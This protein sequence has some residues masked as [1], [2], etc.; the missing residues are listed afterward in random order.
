MLSDFEKNSNRPVLVGVASGLHVVC[1]SKDCRRMPGTS[2]LN[3][4]CLSRSASMKNDTFISNP[5]VARVAFKVVLCHNARAF[6]PG[7]TDMLIRFKCFVKG[8]VVEFSLEY[9]EISPPFFK[10]VKVFPLF[11]LL[12]N[13]Y[14]TITET[15]VYQ[16]W[17]F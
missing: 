9:F 12:S 17:K 7:F 4:C 16:I 11:H 13:S 6:C 1:S 10:L 2:W 3:A 8:C 15:E 14:K 5:S